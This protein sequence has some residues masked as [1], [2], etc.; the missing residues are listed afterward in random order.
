MK[1]YMPRDMRKDKPGG[2]T[3]SSPPPDSRQL[4]KS[5]VASRLA[6]YK[7]LKDISGGKHLDDA[8]RHA[9]DLSQRDRA[10]VRLLVTTVLR[11][12]GQIDRVLSEIMTK[13]PAGRTRDAIEIMRLGA[14]QL[15]FLETGAHAAVDSTVD[16]MRAAGFHSMT[17]LANAVMRRLSRDGADIL[18]TTDPQDNLPDWIRQS[19]THHWGAARTRQTMELAMMPPPLDITP[20]R[21]PADW[22]AHLD[23]TL[24][25]GHTIRRDFDGDPTQLAGFEDGA[26]WVQDAA[27]ALP[28]RLF[29]DIAGRRVV[30]LCAAPGG[31]TAQLVAAG[32]MVTA[33][34]TSDRRLRIL[35]RNLQRLGMAAE[36]VKMDGRRYRPADTVDAVL[37]DAPCSAT[38]TLRRRPD[39]PGHRTPADVE[40]LTKTQTELLASA[41]EWL[42]PGGCLIYAT[43][44]LQ[45]EEGEAIIDAFLRR[46]DS[47]MTIEPVS[48][49]EAGLFAPALTDSGTLRIVPADFAA[50][51]GVD[52]FFIARLKSHRN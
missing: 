46:P 40:S 1:T 25:D 22:A 11:R 43:C 47:H 19:W 38:G 45:H 10:F 5:G 17:G 8:M 26:W 27:A 16:M 31:K 4:A 34:D 41:S 50:L 28:A 20:A 33:I 44:S 30:D 12:H 35:R 24:I 7:A 2:H 51:G 49:A 37:I 9:G 18:A 32:A 3:K 13:R 6:A 21:D 14:A 52:G 48:P 15:L 36:M 42:A 39:V 29:G 23:G